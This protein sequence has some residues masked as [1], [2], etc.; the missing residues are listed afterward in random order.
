MMHAD[1]VAQR[2]RISG[3]ERFCAVEAQCRSAPSQALDHG[4]AEMQAQLNTQPHTRL[5]Q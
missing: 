1:L 5:R 2:P 3:R 4:R